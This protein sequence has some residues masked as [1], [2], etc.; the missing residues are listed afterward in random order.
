VVPGM[1]H[2]QDLTFVLYH[3]I[4]FMLY[5]EYYFEPP[6]SFSAGFTVP[7]FPR[8]LFSCFACSNAFSDQVHK[9]PSLQ[10]QVR[11]TIDKCKPPKGSVALSDKREE[12]CLVKLWR[13][14]WMVTH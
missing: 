13:M 1:E 12:D 9:L 10:T 4:L 14:D 7:L 11:C 2:K 3:W 6:T 8:V 5:H